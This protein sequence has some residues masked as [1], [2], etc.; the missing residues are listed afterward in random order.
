MEIE[1]PGPD[2]GKIELQR[3]INCMKENNYE[4]DEYLYAGKYDGCYKLKFEEDRL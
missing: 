2:T 1:Y 4:Y 3:I